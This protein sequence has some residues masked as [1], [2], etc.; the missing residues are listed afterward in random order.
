MSK[1]GGTAAKQ[2]RIE[3]YALAYEHD[4]DFEAVMVAARQRQVA[5]FLAAR[6]PRIVVEAGCGTELLCRRA[7]ELDIP[8]ER[9]VIVE[10]SRRF[11]AGARAR[12]CASGRVAVVESFL[13]DAVVAVTD[14]GGAGADVVIC[15][16]LLHEVSEPAHFLAAARE[17]LA[18][19][20]HLYVDVPNARSL[21]RRLARGMGLIAHETELSGRNR[22]LAQDRVFDADSLR[23]ELS[24][25]GFR[26]LEEGG[27]FL[28][29]FT[30]AQ[31]ADLAFL[32]ARMADGL[33]EIG[34]ELPD[35]AAEIFCVAEPAV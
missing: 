33:C 14:E 8:F 26:I 10:P 23:A 27:Y 5:A 18:A 34:R 11:A 6:R 3:R 1:T 30:S 22:A 16:S 15:S 9:W 7:E 24:A 28:K 32:D 12:A 4:Y 31:M 29:P 21:H 25:A 20:G 17:L 35:L 19:D 13:E 2:A